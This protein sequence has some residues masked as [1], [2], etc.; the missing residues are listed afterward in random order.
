MHEK[1]V[2]AKGG[3]TL[4]NDQSEPFPDPP[5]DTELGVRGL[6]SASRARWSMLIALQQVTDISESAEG[7]GQHRRGIQN[8]HNEEG[9]EP[10]VGRLDRVDDGGE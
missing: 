5:P 3:I 6:V 10:V 9:A 1:K 7:E 2:V 4:W 8:R